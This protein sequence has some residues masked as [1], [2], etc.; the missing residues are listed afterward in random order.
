MNSKY[1]FLTPIICAL[2][3]MFGVTQVGIQISMHPKIDDPN[4]FSPKVFI[5]KKCSIFNNCH[6]IINFSAT[7]E[8]QEAY[9]KLL[10]TLRTA[11]KN[12]TITIYLAGFGGQVM[13]GM[14]IANAIKTTNA[15][16]IIRVVGDVYSM[17]AILALCGKELHISPGVNFLF[18]LANFP[19]PTSDPKA[20]NLLIAINSSFIKIYGPQIQKIL[21]PEEFVRFLNHDDVIVDGERVAKQLNAQVD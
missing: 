4:E 12:D 3:L 17:D 1:F 19:K 8:E 21:T 20:N 9:I 7:I 11:T 15:N 18:H 5:D 6:Y 16:V 10:S 2:I 14:Q 13:S